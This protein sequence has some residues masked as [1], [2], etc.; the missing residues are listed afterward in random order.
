MFDQFR[1]SHGSPVVS[2]I[3]FRCRFSDCIPKLYPIFSTAPRRLEVF[4]RLHRHTAITSALVCEFLPQLMRQI[5]KRAIIVRYRLNTH[6]TRRVDKLMTRT[7]R[8]PLEYS[9]P[10]LLELHPFEYHWT[11]L[12]HS[13][14]V[15]QAAHEIGRLAQLTHCNARAV[16]KSPAPL[17]AFLRHISLFLPFKD[18]NYKGINKIWA[19]RSPIWDC[20][21]AHS[22]TM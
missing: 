11:Y 12:K 1:R 18:V 20:K 13:R 15:N 22:M 16:Q 19:E 6:H 7:P 8:P 5:P 9:P 17:Y 14:L 3:T 4:F 10:Y 21:E 2:P